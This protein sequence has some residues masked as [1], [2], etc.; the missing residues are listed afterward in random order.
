MPLMSSFKISIRERFRLCQNATL[1][2]AK[3][4]VGTVQLRV[5]DKDAPSLK[6]E[7]FRLCQN[8]TLD[9]AKNPVG[10]V[11]LRVPDK[12]APSLKG[13]RFRL[14]PR[15]KF[16]IRKET[17]RHKKA[18]ANRGFFSYLRGSLRQCL[19]TYSNLPRRIR[20]YGHT[21][22]SQASFLKFG[23]VWVLPMTKT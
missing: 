2:L 20:V 14:C 11:Q 9:L 5:P 12:D 23:M 4:P 18:P 8:A 17:S 15:Q 6:G 7:R 3:N 16:P 1:D 21:G 10:T 22:T 13:E 19:D